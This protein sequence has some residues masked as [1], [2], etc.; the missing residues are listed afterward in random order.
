MIWPDLVRLHLIFHFPLW[1][2]LLKWSMAEVLRAAALVYLAGGVVSKMNDTSRNL[3][4]NLHYR[5]MAR[6]GD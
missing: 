5:T 1:G 6:C 2:L 4:E 3:G